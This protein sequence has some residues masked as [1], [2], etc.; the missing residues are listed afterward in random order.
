MFYVERVGVADNSA[1]IHDVRSGKTFDVTY[2]VED[3]EDCFIRNLQ[4]FHK[5]QFGKVN[6]EVEF[7]F[8]GL[9]EETSGVFRNNSRIDV[10][11]EA[12]LEDNDQVR[13]TL[14]QLTNGQIVELSSL[15]DVLYAL[16][17]DCDLEL[18]SN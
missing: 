8:G 16:N 14:S 7:V 6:N 5:K 9:L 12:G 15:E 13:E 2:N 17:N 3:S 4:Y 1:I 10:I 18:T 11:T